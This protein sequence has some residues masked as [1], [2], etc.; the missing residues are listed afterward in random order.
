MNLYLSP[1]TR[2]RLKAHEFSK[3][4]VLK[5]KTQDSYIF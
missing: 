3:S 1:V 5:V 4:G 2:T